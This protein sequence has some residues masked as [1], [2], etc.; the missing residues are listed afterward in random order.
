MSTRACGLVWQGE[1]AAGAATVVHRLHAS[2]CSAALYFEDVVLGAC[3]DLGR[4]TAI[5]ATNGTQTVAI[6]SGALR[7]AVRA[8]QALSVHG[9]ALLTYHVHLAQPASIKAITD[10]TRMTTRRGVR[11][12]RGGGMRVSSMPAPPRAHRT[13]ERKIQLWQESGQ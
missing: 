2:M 4:G 3:S 1:D 8:L 13:A 6:Q 9:L 7:A 5:L 10:K 11:A 12:H